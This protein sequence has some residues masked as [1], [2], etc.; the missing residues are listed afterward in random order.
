MKSKPRI[1]KEILAIKVNAH[2]T[3]FVH[4]DPLSNVTISKPE[5][6]SAYSAYPELKRR[7]YSAL[8]EGDEGELSLAIPQQ[9]AITLSQPLIPPL[10][11][12]QNAT[13]T[14]PGTAAVATTS[15]EK[16]AK[17][18]NPLV[19]RIEY[20]LKDPADGLQFILPSDVYP[21]VR[22]PWCFVRR[23]D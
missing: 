22:Y 3:T 11:Q 19:V 15:T 13:G 18:Y 7:L 1:N 2:P 5:D 10:A 21:Y 17:E 8:A 16:V 20:A 4:H 9:V 23:V 14:G 12:Q 6:G